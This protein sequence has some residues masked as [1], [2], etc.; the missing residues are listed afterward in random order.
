MAAWGLRDAPPADARIEAIGYAGST[1]S[2]KQFVRVEYL[3]VN[4]K[5]YGL[6][7]GPA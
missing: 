2:G 5:G 1:L 3:W 6:R 7:S 4:G